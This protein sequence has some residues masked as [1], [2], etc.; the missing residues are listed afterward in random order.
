MITRSAV[1]LALALLLPSLV[2]AIAPAQ[3]AP[4]PAPAETVE[5]PPLTVSA[6]V[7][8]PGAALPLSSIPSSVQVV[9]GEMLRNSGAVSLQDALTRLPGIHLND[10]QGNSVQF[11]LSMRGF[12]ATSVTG[13]PQGV[14]VFIDGVRVNE[15][16]VEEVNFD[17]IPLKDIDHIEV[18]RGPSSTFG[19]NT[20]GGAIN[21][22]TRRGG[23]G[24][25]IVPEADWGSF[26][27][28]EYRLQGGGA[29]GPFDFY[30]SGS[31]YHEN[32]WRDGAEVQLGKVFAK[33][34]F[35]LAET[36][37]TVSYQR[38]Q[39]RIEQAGS[40]PASELAVDRTLNFTGGDFFKP[41]MNLG[42]LS[43]RQG[44]GEK[45]TLTANAFIRTL[46]AEQFNV[47]LTGP[48]ARSFYDTTSLGGS[49]QLDYD[50]AIF[51]HGNRLT[52]GIEYVHHHVPFETFLEAE[53]TGGETL[54]SKLTDNQNAFAVY[55]E[56]TF[57]IA[58]SL[59][60]NGDSLV[61]TLG[62]RWDWL[63]HEI[64]D[65]S[66]PE[67]ERPSAS[68]TSTFNRANPRFGINYNL[69]P[70]NGA[71]FTFAQ[72]FRAPAFLELSCAGPAA[73]CPGLQAGVAQDPPLNPVRVN[74]YEIGARVRPFQW[75]G[76]EAA[77]YRTDVIDDI[78]AV[79]P[80]GT[81]GVF[82]Q[83]VGNTR[84]QGLE[85]DAQATVARDWD[86]RLNYTY[87]Q[88]TFRSDLELTTSRLVP[89][90]DEPPCTEPVQKG[91]DLPL[92]PR[93]RLNVSVDYRV[94][95]WLTLWVS[96]A[97]V[98]SQWFRGD[99]ENVEPKLSS[100]FL[101]SAGVRARYRALSAFLTI[102]NLLN[103]KY[104]TFGTFAPNA[105]AAGTP[106]EPFLTPAPPINVVG[107]LS[108]HF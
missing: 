28:Q 68:G 74:H 63:R 11:D 3:Q 18:I 72:G 2:P 21:I 14:S 100:Y 31:Y 89:G 78:Y 97:F 42:T 35:R 27:R 44:L 4:A 108:Y 37:L 39:N 104:E 30:A 87:T 54:D 62:I 17:L 32:G 93:H 103:N 81:T 45:L 65:Q 51:G 7:R 84:R 25:E 50:G 85:L 55:L 40:L 49:A 95:P 20:L 53:D 60:R 15:P 36:D 22:I 10:E 71:Y 83:N 98:S 29:A 70:S 96:G 67:A 80:T 106:I 41:L 9:P 38:A 13:V 16:T 56:D 48:N 26:G 5:L 75:L 102:N 82:F 73:V 24:L 90:C 79:T 8:L 91:N 23:Q 77:L 52:T 6:P 66:P 46:D 61:L 105:K 92:I 94:A 88:A 19:R 58:R 33:L 86:L 47:N 64:D 43:L 99:E 1:A 69:T 101:M 76:I 107:G 12:T 57:D 34:G 59:F